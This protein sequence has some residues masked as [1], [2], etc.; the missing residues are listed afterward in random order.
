LLSGA[1]AVPASAT[2]AS[3]AAAK[4]PV[5]S[6][7]I[8]ADARVH[9]STHTSLEY[10]LDLI[11]G[12]TGQLGLTLDGKAH[13]SHE[14][15]F[16]VTDQAI[17]V[18]AVKGTGTIRTRRQL[19]RYGRLTLAVLA[20]TK[21]HVVGCRSASGFTTTREVTLKGRQRFD[22]HSG[23][24]GWGV[25]HHKTMQGTLDVTHGSG[26]A[27]KNPSRVCHATGI[28]L[29]GQAGA[30]NLQADGS[31]GKPSEIVGFR[32]VKL[33]SPKHASRDDILVAAGVPLVA[34][35]VAGGNLSFVIQGTAS[36]V[37]GSATVTT[38]SPPTTSRCR[39]TTTNDYFPAQWRNG[40][41]QLTLHA[42]IEGKITVKN[43][44][45]AGAD[46]TTK[47]SSVA[48]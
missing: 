15:D 7:E 10:Q 14:W 24:H 34:S 2:A 31:S 5:T 12:K 13:E 30:N 29:I 32:S 9:S 48:G 8:F 40:A 27:G 45:S 25:V 39:K 26:C 18:D 3:T 33:P 23:S 1:A 36:N 44:K 47:R 37:T 21:A 20:A 42:Q 11:H 46:V 28:N 6:F 38:K 35:D 17:H 43:N 16:T 4:P 41:K 19:K 22:T